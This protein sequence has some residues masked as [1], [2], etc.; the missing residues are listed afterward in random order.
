MAV[1]EHPEKAARSTGRPL[2]ATGETVRQNI[3]RIRD[4]HGISGSELSARLKGLDRP[5][6]PLGIHRIEN[7]T[8]RVNV[9]D[10]TALAV[11]L[12]VSPVTLL[13]PDTPDAD[14]RISVGPWD[15]LPASVAW[16]WL[17]AELAVGSGPDDGGRSAARYYSMSRPVWEQQPSA[18]IWPEGVDTA[19][20]DS[21]ARDAAARAIHDYLSGSG[22]G[23]S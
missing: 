23:N 2:G 12:D 16:Q 18:G 11:A 14:T 13:M 6:P 3:R 19:K 22:D 8:R 20:L 17:R 21:I 7:G 9:D 1:D 4:E 15:E 10:L 5:I